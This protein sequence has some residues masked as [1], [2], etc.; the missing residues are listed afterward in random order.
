VVFRVAAWAV[1]A[2]ATGFGQLTTEQKL[3]D[4]RHLAALYAKQYAPYEWKL[5]A[6]RFD[7]LEIGEWLDR[8]RATRDDL[9][10][11]DLMIEYVA[12]LNDAHDAYT[13]PSTFSATLGF[14]VDIYDGR[15][16]V[17]FI[18]RPRLPAAEYPFQIGD[19]L[20]SVDGR[21]V[22]SL[23]AEFARYAV[24][25]NPRSTRRNA[26]DRITTRPQSRMPRAV[27]L[28]ERAEVVIRRAGGALERYSLPWIKT[29]LEMRAAGPVPA[30]ERR[31]AAGFEPDPLAP[32]RELQ[33]CELPPEAAVRGL[34]ARTPVFV[35][36]AGFSQRLGRAPADVFFSGV[37]PA[38]GYR[39]G[40]LRIPGYSPSDSAAALDQFRREIAYFQENTDGLIVDDMRN[41][42]GSIAYVNALL[43][44]LIPYRF[45]VVGFEIRATSNWVV[46]FSTALESARARGAETSLVRLYEAILADLMTAN[47]ENRGRTGPLPLDD[48]ALDR[49]PV[50]EANGAIAAYTKPLLVLVDEFSASGGEAFA[51]TLQDNRRAVLLGMRT[52]GA[53]GSVVTVEVG[54]YSE[55]STGMTQ[56]LMNRGSAVVTAEYP[57]APYIENIGVRPDIEV[58]FMTRE[59]LLNGGRAFVEAF[60]A[61]MVEHI[62]A[63]GGEKSP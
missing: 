51:A 20:V 38:Q 46:R 28:G 4:F 37:F 47:R 7:L 11:Y 19:E 53:G 12:R 41:A 29:G 26:A 35:L 60:T 33:N 6:E 59:T 32:L 43:Q 9:E 54:S 40:F 2:S 39:I 44:H 48:A 49:E 62:R 22:E 23:L 58:D 8:A 24:A 21:D 13:L 27:E 61:A 52:M 31:P 56:A 34:G 15:V 25:G 17:N 16:L 14:G 63:S 57:A 42:G 36:P 5:A 45:R 30:P 1:L 10:F 18:N 55:G 50:R 3:A